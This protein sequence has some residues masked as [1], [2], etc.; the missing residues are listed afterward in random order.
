M[1]RF[2]ISVVIGYMLKVLKSGKE[3]REFKKEFAAIRHDDYIKFI[4]L[5][6]GPMPFMVMYNAGT[7]TSGHLTPQKDDIDFALL[8]KS[9]P[10]C[11]IFYA[12]CL[13]A[14]CPLKDCDISDEIYEQL[15]IFEISLRIHANNNKLTTVE[16]TLFTII[17]KLGVHKN[18]T[19]ID[20]NKIDLGRKFLN[21]VKH[22]KKQ[23]SSW[24]EGIT[25][26]KI[27]FETLELHKLSV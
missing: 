23:F 6:K 19:S 15:A 8:L 26:F 20:V 11:K 3:I 10:S 18:I 21:M 14:Y 12:N 22:N 17:S 7:I 13:L 16:D 24:S 27:A 2:V 9:G 4:D 1:E 25:A 5:V